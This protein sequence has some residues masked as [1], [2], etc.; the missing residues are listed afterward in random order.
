MFVLDEPSHS[1]EYWGELVK[2]VTIGVSMTRSNSTRFLEWRLLPEQINSVLTENVCAT[3]YL[4]TR[5]G[6]KELSLLA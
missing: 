6:K 1:E 4:A 3:G 2:I 5:T